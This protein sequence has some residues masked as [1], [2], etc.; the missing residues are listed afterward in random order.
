MSG[1]S[2]S[3]GLKWLAL[4]LLLALTLGSKWAVHS[5][6]SEQ[7]SRPSEKELQLRVAG[8]LARQ[9]FA[10]ALSG[11]V[12]PGQPM[13]RATAPMCNMLIVESPVLDWDRD[14]L[15]REAG[16]S[17]DVFVVFF[18]RIYT[19]QPTWLTVPYHLWSRLRSGFGLTS[20]A[21]PALT[22]IATRNCDAKQLPWDQLT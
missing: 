3:R 21:T 22:V 5:R 17:D 8:F 10:V 20:Q 6:P 15:R 13:I 12:A 2:S 7:A 14:Q 4:C 9:R 16:P 1:V 11:E 18:G 19:D